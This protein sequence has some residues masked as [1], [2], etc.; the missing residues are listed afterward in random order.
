MNGREISMLIFFI[1][2]GAHKIRVLGSHPTPKYS[3]VWKLPNKH[4]QVNLVQV[5]NGPHFGE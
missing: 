5:D 4:S 2:C 1:T 3:E